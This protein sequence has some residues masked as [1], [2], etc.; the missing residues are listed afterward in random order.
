M[1]FV[2][3]AGG[4]PVPVKVKLSAISRPAM[5]ASIKSLMEDFG[6]KVM[7]GYVVHPGDV[8]LPLGSHVTALTFSEL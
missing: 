2:I 4:R 7:P 6:E 8:R 3:E 5:A 1:D